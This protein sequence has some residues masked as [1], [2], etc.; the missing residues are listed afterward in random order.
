MTID[1]ISDL[2]S[3]DSD[4]IGELGNGYALLDDEFFLTYPPPHFRRQPFTRFASHKQKN[5]L[6]KIFF[7]L[8]HYPD[9][10][11]HIS[12]SNTLKHHIEVCTIRVH[13]APK[14]VLAPAIS[15]KIEKNKHAEQLAVY[16]FLPVKA[17]MMLLLQL[18]HGLSQCDRIPFESS[19][20]LSQI[21]LYCFI[22][23]GRILF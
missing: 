17:S 3:F 13:R 5:V 7:Q 14:S 16:L 9:V 2:R 23:Q 10:L 8:E 22:H 6:L 4:H 11:A 15:H 21:I 12:P 20:R 19:T 1:F 18:C